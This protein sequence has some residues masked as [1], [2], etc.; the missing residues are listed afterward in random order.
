[1]QLVCVCVC[2]RVG[3]IL[4]SLSVLQLAQKVCA[5]VALSFPV[6]SC[7][8]AASE[9]LQRKKNVQHPQF[10]QG[11]RRRGII[12]LISPVRSKGNKL[13]AMPS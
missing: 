13:K 8:S 12:M 9:T 4:S 1:M 7:V 11:V 10:L 6:S 2:V 3:I 5:E